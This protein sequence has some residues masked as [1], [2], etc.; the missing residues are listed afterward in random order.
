MQ[1]SKIEWTDYTWNPI[2][3]CEKGC[4]YCYA[5]KL[6]KRYPK[7]FP[8]G[9]KPTFYPDRLNDPAK[10]KS[11]SKIFVCSMGE[12]F[13]E[14]EKWTEE[15]L[16]KIH[17]FEHATFQILTKQPERMVKWE[18]PDNAWVGVSATDREQLDIALF[19]LANVDAKVKFISFEP[20]QEQM[21]LSPNDLVKTVKW[22]IIG[23]QTPVKRSN[24]PDILW[25][26][27][28][29]DAAD[30]AG[31][32]VFLKNNLVNIMLTPSIDPEYARYFKRGG[33]RR[34]FPKEAK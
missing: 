31:I 8:A 32:P 18:I 25:V 12:L 10:A 28:I 14:N 21:K 3:G 23:Q 30:Q 16:A 19:Y 33:L 1:E 34:D 22:V 2:T 26:K 4:D 15:V 29:V 17:Y 13:G 7:V 11:G 20:L 9:F 5:R 27:E 6:T 24:M